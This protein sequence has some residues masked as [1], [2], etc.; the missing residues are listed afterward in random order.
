MIQWY[1]KY[2]RVVLH[3]YYNLR[4]EILYIECTYIYNHYT[5]YRINFCTVLPV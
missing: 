4:K 5:L 3:I 2:Q 1:F